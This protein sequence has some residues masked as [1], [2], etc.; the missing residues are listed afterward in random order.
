MIQGAGV[1]RGVFGWIMVDRLGQPSFTKVL[2]VNGGS[3]G[4]SA[5]H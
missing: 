4:S 2:F 1:G 5:L 3:D